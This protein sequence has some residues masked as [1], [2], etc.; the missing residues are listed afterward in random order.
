[1]SMT[2]RKSQGPRQQ[3]CGLKVDVKV[4]NSVAWL[5][6]DFAGRL[7]AFME[8]LILRLASEPSGR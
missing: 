3:D 5:N 2:C 7:H 1:M 8:P 6:I 4:R